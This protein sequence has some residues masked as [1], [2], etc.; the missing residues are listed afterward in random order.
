MGRGGGGAADAGGGA[1]APTLEAEVAGSR[2]GTRASTIASTASRCTTA[3]MTKGVR[4]DHYATIP[5]R[6]VLLAVAISFVLWAV[7]VL[8]FIWWFFWR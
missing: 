3:A 8:P 2:A 4:M 1:D 5:M 7:L 6:A